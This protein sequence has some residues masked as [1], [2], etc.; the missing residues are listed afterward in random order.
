MTRPLPANA[1][2][3]ARAIEARMAAAGLTQKRLALLAG[4]NETYVR[5]I[6][7]GKSRNPKHEQL[8]KLAT[9]LGCR[10][11]DLTSSPAEELLR[12]VEV[13]SETDGDSETVY[14][15]DDVIFVRLWKMLD[16]RAKA[17]VLREAI[18]RLSAG[19]SKSG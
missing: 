7:R 13:I 9:A 15:L 17:A 16:R 18:T 11:Q 8:A 4:L 10:V 6:L 12:S 2:S 14:E 5:D 3:L 19:R 1:T